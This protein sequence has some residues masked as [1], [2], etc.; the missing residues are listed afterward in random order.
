MREQFC[1]R[2]IRRK[3]SQKLGHSYLSQ[4]VK[5]RKYVVNPKT[6]KAVVVSKDQFGLPP[7]EMLRRRRICRTANGSVRNADQKI[8]KPIRG[9]MA[10]T[11]YAK[12]IRL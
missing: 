12:T 4:K 11:R 7:I 2:L 1:A 6:A 8:E 9:A 10:K 3:K 5:V